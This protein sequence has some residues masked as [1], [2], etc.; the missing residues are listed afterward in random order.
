M[1]EEEYFDEIRR[2]KKR[3]KS[4]DDA[5]RIIDAEKESFGGET[6]EE[7][8]T[9]LRFQL[10]KDI[11]N[12]AWQL[13]ATIILKLGQTAV[14]GVAGLGKLVKTGSGEEAAKTI[15]DVQSYDLPGKVGLS[16][17]A[18]DR[19][20]GAVATGGEYIDIPFNWLG[21]KA[22]D[23]TGSPAVGTAVYTGS[24]LVGPAALK[25][26]FNTATGF[27]K[28]FGRHV[29]ID[30]RPQTKDVIS[31]AVSGVARMI[32]GMT[33]REGYYG[34]HPLDQPL[35]F[36]E[37]GIRSIASATEAVF[38]PRAAAIL[39]QHGVSP[40]SVRRIQ[41]Y[42][43]ELDRKDLK[44]IKR[45]HYEKVLVAELEKAYAMKLK[46]GEAASPELSA[47]MVDYYPRKLEVFGIPKPKELQ[48]VIQGDIPLQELRYLI[49]D[50]ADTMGLEGRNNIYALG[51]NPGRSSMGG[52]KNNRLKT[53][54]PAELFTGPRTAYEMVGDIWVRIAKGERFDFTKTKPGSNVWFSK[55][56]PGADARKVNKYNSL[57]PIEFNADTLKRIMATKTTIK[58][59][60]IARDAAKEHPLLSRFGFKG[61]R[62]IQSEGT[63]VRP[64]KI[65]GKDYIL[66]HVVSGSDN[67]ML[68]STPAAILLNPRTGTSRILA[69]DELDLL[70]GKTRKIFDTGFSHGFV[71][72]NSGSFTYSDDILKQV[73]IKKRGKGEEIVKTKTPDIDQHITD[74]LNTS[75]APEL[76][77]SGTIPALTSI[78]TK[79]NENR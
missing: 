33:K 56:P 18:L 23:V 72:V 70:S 29:L 6:Q 41:A 66:Y 43:K 30:Q 75:A 32:P 5:R 55:P 10:A 21:K 46:A 25:G 3:R 63:N 39:R 79:R 50:M 34:G 31:G 60:D 42:R 48:T 67:P 59:A 51:G 54:N 8:I 9:S 1:N 62:R 14:A 28:T 27:G 78:K 26:M 65:N 74:M 40:T 38:N 53:E 73:G 58:K 69:F 76:A 7:Y 20:V 52:P 24:Q 71:T 57:D 16:G 2:L 19:S 17:P 77:Q 36:V 12:A 4:E 22:T 37:S 13:P 64:A 15:E 44:P 35:Q 45:E 49:N 11:G 47:I 61:T 68:A